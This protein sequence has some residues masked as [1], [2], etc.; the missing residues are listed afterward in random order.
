MR[1]FLQCCVACPGAVV[2]SVGAPR[3]LFLAPVQVAVPAAVA[4]LARALAALGVA[5]V[6]VAAPPG[7]CPT[8]AR[9]THPEDLVAAPR[10]LFLAPVQVAVPAAVA[11]LARALAALGVAVVGVAAPPGLCPTAARATHPED[12]VAAPPDLFLA[13]VQ[14]AVPAVAAALARALAA[15][16]GVAVVGVAAPPGLC[17]T[18]ARAMHPED[19]VAAPRDLFLAPVQVAVPAAVAA[20]A[21]ALA[22]LGVAVVGVAA[23]P[24]LCPT[25]VRATHPEDLVA[26]PRDLF[27]A[28][29]QVAAPA[30]VAALARALAALGVAVVGAA[31][32]PGLCP[33]VAVAADFPAFQILLPVAALDLAVYAKAHK[34][35]G[36]KS[37]FSFR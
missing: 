9:A 16:L 7:L 6:G 33:A 26:A 22:A 4:A 24:G 28:P 35:F 30:A 10:V 5:V 25:A 19:L 11:A 2:A 18:A 1:T 36:R 14:V 13:P 29:V 34:R 27:L 37:G 20:L 23:P 21:R 32:P 8:A 17:P 3:D 12:L 31:A 15:A